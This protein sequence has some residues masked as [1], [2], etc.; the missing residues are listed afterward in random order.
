MPVPAEDVPEC[1]KVRAGSK[2][3]LLVKKPS[4]YQL[5]AP[6]RTD[7][8]VKKLQR[9]APARCVSQ[10]PSTAGKISSKGMTSKQ[11]RTHK[12]A[13][14]A[15]AR[16][17]CAAAEPQGTPALSESAPNEQQ[18]FSGGDSAEGKNSR[19]AGKDLLGAGKKSCGFLAEPSRKVDTA[20]AWGRS[21]SAGTGTLQ[22]KG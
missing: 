11:G 21:S 7:P 9:K 1:R 3:P 5:R 20:G 14:G 19:A 8:E 17:V 13:A 10:G 4:P 15:S 18:S 2:K 16:E 12:A 6:Y 22:E